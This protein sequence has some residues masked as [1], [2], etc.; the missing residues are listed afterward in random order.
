[1]TRSK[2]LAAATIALLTACGPKGADS[3][4]ASAAPR[5]DAQR[6]AAVALAM[7]AAPTKG[8]SVLAAHGYTTAQLEELLYRVAADSALNAEY[9]RLTTP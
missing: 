3:E 6:A 8:D 4:S 5:N 9:L 2:I 7:R 1:M